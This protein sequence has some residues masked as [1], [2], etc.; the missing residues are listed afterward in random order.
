MIR[1]VKL[2]TNLKLFGIIRIS[3]AGFDKLDCKLVQSVE[4][5]RCM[6]Y[7]V[8]MDVEKSQ[9]LEDCLLELSLC[10]YIL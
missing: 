8:P 9:I 6:R 4:I 10:A 2:P 5:V 1:R 3:L 7:A